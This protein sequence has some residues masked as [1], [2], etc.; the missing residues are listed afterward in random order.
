VV[1]TAAVLSR[2]AA[3]PFPAT[4]IA[5]F[6]SCMRWFAMFASLAQ[7]SRSGERVALAVLTR[8]KGSSPQKAGALAL[9]HPDG[10]IEGTLGGGCLEAEAQKLALLALDTG[11]PQSFDLVLDRDFRWDDAMICGGRVTGWVIPD[12]QQAGDAFWSRLANV[13]SAE[14]WGIAADFAF[15][16]GEEARRGSDG[17]LH[18]A[19]AQPP[20]ILWIA[21]AGHIAQAVAPLAQSVGFSVTVFDDRSALASLECFAA[22]IELRSAPWNTLIE[23]IPPPAAYGLVVTRGHEHDALVL[24]KWLTH[25]FVFLGMIGSR[26]KARLMREA[27]VRDGWATDGQMANVECPVGLDIGAQSPQE[28]AVSIVGRL[29]E[30]RA[31][32][33]SEIQ[34]L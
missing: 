13:T 20:A 15:V 8:V 5:S 25:P 9:F 21:G 24:Q 28:I 17:L 29:I 27:F 23:L 4:K 34:S 19:V 2:A 1:K 10:R 33:P 32:R 18:H 7:S 31:S 14:H 12:A 11:K 22:G 30:R 6:D 26:R 16:A 3:V